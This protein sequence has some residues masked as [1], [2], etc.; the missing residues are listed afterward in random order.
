VTEHLSGRQMLLLWSGVLIGPI[1]WAFS[2][3]S[4]FWFTH[5]VCQG[6][7]RTVLWVTGGTCAAVSAGA[8]VGAAVWL[9]RARVWRE[10]AEIAPFMLGLG[11]GAGALF[12]LVILL[13]MVP[14]AMLTPCPV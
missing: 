3:T 12:A 10:R 5:P 11:I 14:I 8:C 4:M 9:A 13:S 1:A 7:D 2:L 6:A